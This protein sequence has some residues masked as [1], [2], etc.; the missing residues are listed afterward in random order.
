MNEKLSFGSSPALYPKGEH[1][2]EWERHEESGFIN[3]EGTKASATPI[4]ET[5]NS[6]RMR[7]CEIYLF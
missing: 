7:D 4:D 3:A 2:E 5:S 1:R 6:L